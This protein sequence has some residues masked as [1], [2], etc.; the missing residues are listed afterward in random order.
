MTVTVVC[1]VLGKKNNGTTIAAYNLIE[2]LKAKGHDVRVVCSDA[3]KRGLPGFYVVEPWDF[4]PFNNYVAKNGVVPAKNDPEILSEA[5][6]G[7]DI[8][9]IMTP[10]SLGHAAALE[11]KSRGIPISAGFHAQAENLTS[12]VFLKNFPPANHKVYKVIYNRLYQY[13]DC[14][15]YPS[16]FIR[17]V[18]ENEVGPTNGYVISNGVSDEFHRKDVEKPD[19]LKDK[20]VILFTG[21]YSNEKSHKV[22][23]LAAAKSKHRDEIR[24]I[25]AGDGPLREKLE[26]LSAK[27]LPAMPVMGLHPRDELIDIVN[28]SDLY[29]HPAEIE[30]E[31]I[32]CL[33][34]IACGLVPV[35]SDS[36]RSATRFFAL[37]EENLFKC[38][39]HA[40]LARKI[41]YWIEHPDKRTECSERYLGFSE[42]HA[43]DKC[44]D[45]MERML[46]ENSLKK[47][48]SDK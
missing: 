30:I 8:I 45:A 18:F 4:G 29:V 25:F 27:L 7:A 40:D 17:E 24:L 47:G 46:V 21:R 26:K 33:E 43:F 16:E 9:H 15:H 14:I 36:K 34:A 6:S 42:K 39:D 37:G 12:H 22:L 32:A 13:C 11:A 2:S 23:I 41:D 5:L 3:E 10:F 31:A 38:N 1:D 20:F 35:I 28:Y 44:M 19:G 48:G